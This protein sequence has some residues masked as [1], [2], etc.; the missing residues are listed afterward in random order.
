MQTELW[1]S[2]ARWG[3][4]RDK[5]QFEAICLVDDFSGSGSSVIRYDSDDKRWKGKVAKFH[6]ANLERIGKELTE[7]CVIHIHHHL[8]SAQAKAQI[9][10][11]VERFEK[12]CPEFRYI[13]SFSYVLPKEIAIDDACTDTDLVALFKS[14]YD[15]NI[16]D[17]HTK[18][19][20]WFGYKKCGLPLVLEHNTPNNS[21]ALL[22]AESE[23]GA[24]PLMKPLF[25]RRKRHSS[26][27]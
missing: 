22:W 26:N 13:V 17:E 4:S 15:P 19:D 3:P 6:K 7:D 18:K 11:D 20:I 23:A 2:L 24:N 5:A 8:A 27:G 9:E 14:W 16:E 1:K 12:A 10:A 25:A 21:V